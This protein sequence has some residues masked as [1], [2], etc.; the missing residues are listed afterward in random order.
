[1][2]TNESEKMINVPDLLKCPCCLETNRKLYSFIPCL[3]ATCAECS[4][5][6]ETCPICRSAI[7]TV[8]NNFIAHQ[9]YEIY[10]QDSNDKELT[11]EIER[12]EMTIISPIPDVTDEPNQINFFRRHNITDPLSLLCLASGIAFLITSLLF[13]IMWIPFKVDSDQQIG[14]NSF[15]NN[16]T[17]IQIP[18]SIF[19]DGIFGSEW[20]IFIKSLNINSTISE[21]Y[22]SEEEQTNRLK[23]FPIHST[24]ICFKISNSRFSWDKE[25]VEDGV[26]V[27]GYSDLT[28]LIIG[29]IC[30]IC[31]IIRFTYLKIKSR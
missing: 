5:K 25:I 4:K 17:I 18:Q 31:F 16:I 28:M 7:E 9:I 19:N 1:M 24:K 21:K 27:I 13:F 29:I 6:C 23:A 22:S 3:H 8:K 26:N 12:T 10:N 30:I 11:Q 14:Y 2:T 20:N 15:I